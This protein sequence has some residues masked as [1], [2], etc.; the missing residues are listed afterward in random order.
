MIYKNNEDF[1]VG[2]TSTYYLL[3]NTKGMPDY[4]NT[5]FLFT[6]NELDRAKQRWEK[7]GK[8]VIVKKGFFGRGKWELTKKR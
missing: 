2:E 5:N 3:E 8:P 4:D 6:K 7:K 1:I